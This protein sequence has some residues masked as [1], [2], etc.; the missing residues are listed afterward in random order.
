MAIIFLLV[1]LNLV[2]N[3]VIFEARSTQRVEALN[4]IRRAAIFVSREV[5]DR[6]PQLPTE[7]EM[8][9]LQDQS[10]LTGLG[11]I[12]MRPKNN[13]DPVRRDWFRA[14]MRHFP[15]SQFPELVDKLYRAEIN[16]L[17]RG[18]DAE[19]YY[20]YP[21]PAGAG[22]SLLVLSIDRPDL[23]YLDDARFTLMVVLIGA[24]AI[25]L[26]VYAWLSRFMFRPFRRLKKHAAQAGRPLDESEDETEAVIEEYERVI[27]QLTSTKSE[28]LYL[29]EELGKRVDSIELFNRYLLDSNSSGVI[30]LDLGGKIV[31][32]NEAA[33]SLLDCPGSDFKG[34]RYDILFAQSESLMTDIRQAIDDQGARGYDEYAGL[35]ADNPEAVLGVT[36]ADIRDRESG[37]T[38]LLLLIGDLSELNRLR[39]ELENKKRL[40]ALGEMAG[41]LAH[42]IRNSLGAIGGYGMLLKKRLMR[43]DLPFEHA[44]NLL[45]ES[46]DA[47]ELITRFLS[48][49][50]PFEY[51]PHPTDLSEL[52]AEC[53]ESNRVR[54]DQDRTEIKIGSIPP[55]IINADPILL[56]QALDNLI[57]NAVNAYED[58]GG[59]VEVSVA[60]GAEAVT[61]TV[62]DYGS[63]IPEDEIDKIFTPFFSSRPSGTGLGLPLVAKILALHGGQVTVEST[64][65]KGSKF[66]IS[67][68]VVA[69][70]TSPDATQKTADPV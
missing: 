2:S 41:G 44:D 27:K 61:I 38:G 5:Q 68:P 46:R 1:F 26:L 7:T 39:G 24:V 33:T 30:T 57:D 48:F 52:V 32:I 28:L 63:G 60:S 54:Q 17:T 70:E 4:D 56:K 14:V 3:Y 12:P 25:V 16:Q 51:D 20:L 59:L 19:F 42:Q 66:I 47:G 53:L 69:I 49:A 11:L 50:R 36:L 67:L 34:Q 65:G 55:V 43:E 40:A 22:N 62:A 37:L 9:R 64:L 6:Y 35:I 18:S 8:L 23:A 58:G 15:P 13:T 29:N 21:I 10:G 31:A 45:E